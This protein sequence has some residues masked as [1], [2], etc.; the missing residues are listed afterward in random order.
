LIDILFIVAKRIEYSRDAD[1][2]SGYVQ[3]DLIKEHFVV[4]MYFED[5]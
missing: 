4:E 3:S 5:L 2:V 1:F